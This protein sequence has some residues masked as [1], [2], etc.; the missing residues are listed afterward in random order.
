MANTIP[1]QTATAGT[2]FSYAFPANTFS[3][4]DTGDT[5]TY[6]AT[7]ADDTALPTWLAFAAGTRTFSG[8]PTDAGMVALKVT[9]SDGNGG[10]VSDTFD[11]TVAADTTPPTLTSAGVNEAGLFILLGFS[12]N[13]QLSNLPPASAFTV[14]AGGSAVT[15]GG[16]MPRP[17]APDVFVITVSPAIRQGQ[18]IVVTYT[19][20]TAGDDATAFQDTAGNDAAT[21]TTGSDGVPAVTNASTVNT[22]ATGA[23]TITGMAQVG[24]TLTA[25]TTAIMD[26]NGLTTPGYTYQ[27]IR[28][29]AGVD[30]N[31]SMATA[32]TYTLVTDDLG[33]TIKVKVSFTDD[34]SNPE[35]LTSAATAAVT[36]AATVPGAPTGLMATASGT[37][38]ID[39]SW[40]APASTGGAAITG[41]KIEVSP[42]GTSGW[43][44]QV[45]DTN[46][47][48]TT[49]AHTGLAAGDTRHYRVSAIN[50]NGTGTASNVD[51]ATT[52][53]NNPPTVANTIPDQTATVGTAFSY[54]VSPNGHL[55]LDRPGRRHQQTPLTYLRAHRARRRRR[56]RHYRVSA[57]NTNGTRTASNVDSATTGTN[58]PPT[59]GTRFRT[60]RRPWGRRSSDVQRRGR[61]ATPRPTR[62]RKPPARICPCGWPSPPAR[63]RTFSGTPTAPGFAGRP[64]ALKVT[65]SDGNGGSVSDE[66]LRSSPPRCVAT[67]TG[68]AQV[69][70]TLTAGTT[71][72]MD[73]DGLTSVSYTYQWIRTAA[74]T[75]RPSTYTLVAA[76]LGT[77]VKVRVSLTPVIPRR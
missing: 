11:I 26:A 6:T 20:P 7:K 41:Y 46:S 56:T 31:I 55:R 25:A 50:T 28:T 51:S 32:S 22:P 43:T 69:G 63:C 73:A 34:A 66:Q 33:T 3:D 57:I 15:V 14:T 53:T 71:A 44:D 59:R 9:A 35:T 23:P 29:A 5:L 54:R 76:D 17:G 30:T 74:G 68:T 47:T 4:A 58:N 1:D 61:S 77:T 13:L 18:A 60:R 40:T 62:R 2:A 45:A 52:G 16:V 27:W 10:S 39:L 70:Q 65:A 24:Q 8:T 64:V 21:F 42:N 36:A 19:D 37:T 49:Y 67:I 38:A 48:A 12:E 72:I 75:R